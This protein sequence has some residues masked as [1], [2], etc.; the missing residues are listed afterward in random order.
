MEEKAAFKNPVFIFGFPRSG[1]TLIRSVLGQ[2][3][4]ITLINEPELIW[5]RRHAGCDKGVYR[6]K[7]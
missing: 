6:F 2:H 1:T 4:R 3:S 5:A 7:Y